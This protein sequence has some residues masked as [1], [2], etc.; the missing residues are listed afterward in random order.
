LMTSEEKSADA[1]ILL[2]CF[3]LGGKWTFDRV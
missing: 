1:G 3:I 2:V